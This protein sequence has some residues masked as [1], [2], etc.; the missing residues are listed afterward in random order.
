[1]KGWPQQPIKARQR[2]PRVRRCVEVMRQGALP[3]LS[4]PSKDARVKTKQQCVRGEESVQGTGS[5]EN[6]KK[7]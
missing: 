4:M 7:M 3:P 6:G 1:M 5:Q 2:Y